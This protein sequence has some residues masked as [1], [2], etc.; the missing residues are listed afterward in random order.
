MDELKLIKYRYN[1]SDPIECL[2]GVEIMAVD[3]K[4]LDWLIEQVEKQQREIEY[5]ENR[6]EEILVESGKRWT[7]LLKIRD[8]LGNQL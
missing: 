4:D 1:N 6:K 2:N 7:K 8:I 3:R 5:L